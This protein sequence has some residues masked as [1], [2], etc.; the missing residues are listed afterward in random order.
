MSDCA[1]VPSCGGYVS[2]T[3]NRECFCITLERAALYEALNRESQD[4]DFCSRFIETRPTLF[5]NVPVFLARADIA[6][7]LRIVLAIEAT[8]RSPGYRERVLSWAPDIARRDF[9]PRGVFMGY[10]F[11]LAADGPKLIEINTNAGG[12][13]LNALLARAQQACCAEMEVGLQASGTEDFESAAMDMFRDEWTLQRGRAHLRRI[14]IVDDRP[15]EQY[16]YPEFLL[17][18]RFFQRHGIDAVIVGPEQLRYEGGRLWAGADTIDLVYNRLVDFAFN[19][20]GHASLRAAYLDDAV[21]VTPNPRAHA[22]FADKRN[23]TL[24]SDQAVLR[25]WAV[26][27]DTIAHLRNVPRTVLVSP[28]NADGLWEE[29][30]ELFFKPACG[31]GS[32][33]VYRGDKLTRGVW[34]EVMKGGYVA[35]QFAAPSQRMIKLDGVPQVRKADVRLYAYDGRI[36]ISA[37]RLYQGQATN[38]RTPGGGFAPV[39]AISLGSLRELRSHAD[40]GI[41]GVLWHL[42]SEQPSKHARRHQGANELGQNEPWRVSRANAG[43]CIGQAA[44]YGHSRVGKTGG[45]CEPVAGHDIKG[46][47]HRDDLSAKAPATEDCRDQAERRDHFGQELARP[48]P[49][50]FRHLHERQ[51]EHEMRRQRSSNAATDLCRHVEAKRR[52]WQ[53][54]GSREDQ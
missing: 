38:F 6:A 8:A 28:A 42:R 21:V 46:D 11:H 51:L 43:K 54:T 32:K 14:A 30:R 48:L 19:D 10:D 1:A 15:E 24:L 49:D 41:G 17:A 12:A 26:P 47:R 40:I 22:L 27:S 25:A 20:P 36:L 16:L 34:T 33:A 9:G 13:Y 45:G 50:V 5:S 23:L 52:D 2:Q 39:F 18:Q 35:Q 31:H 37:A 3:L 44:R 29:R 4:P 53:L 7:M